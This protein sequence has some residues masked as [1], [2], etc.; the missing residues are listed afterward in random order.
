M[1][2]VLLP[3]VAALVAIPSWSLA[4]EIGNRF[5][6]VSDNKNPSVLATERPLTLDQ[7]FA[8][9]ET[10]NPQLQRVLAQR[11]AATGDVN[12]TRGLLWN[13][14]EVSAEHAR[15]VISQAGVPG[16]TQR[17]WGVGV[18]QT[19]EV[20]GQQGYRRQA[21]HLQMR[22]LEATIED[23]RREVRFDVE[24]RF[25][26]VLS[27]QERIATERQSLKIIEDT[28]RAVAKRVAAGEDSKLDGNLATV[29]AVR[30]QNQIA[31]LG[32]QLIQARAE[33]AA[34]LQLSPPSLPQ[35]VGALDVTVP[36]YT[37]EQLLAASANRPFLRALAL[38]EQAA[39]NRLSLERAARYPDITLG[40]ARAKEGSAEAPEHLTRLTV[41]LPLPLFRQNAGNIGRASTE[42]TQ[43]QIEQQTGQRNTRADIMALWQ[44]MRSLNARIAALQQT[45][46]PALEENQRLSTKS[47]QAGEISLVQLL[48][49]NRQVLD[50]RRDLIDAL[51][52]MRATRIALDLAA[53][54]PDTNA[55]H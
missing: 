12:D 41:S 9:A 21:A 36:P 44:R 29:E 3:L 18:S 23:T 20:A 40:L 39:Q 8:V 14:P 35:V 19:F 5:S 50:G 25:V 1:Q 13:N 11:A 46:L 30:S 51:T 16:E 49:V 31:A 37:L 4:G 47:L 53:G 7:A 15:R 32:E 17:D 48:L 28:A 42:L 10:A 54:W 52:E 38:R 6:D 55:A 27:L 33:L 24:R 2:V 26:Q 45:V 43:A 34:A 22:A